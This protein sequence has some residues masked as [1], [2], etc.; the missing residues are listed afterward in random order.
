[1]QRVF[2]TSESVTE[3]HPD[4][5]ADRISDAVLDALL[6]EDKQAHVA[7]ETFLTTGLV[8]VGGEISTKVYVD[9]DRVV[10]RVAKEVGYDKAAYGFN[11][12]DC[13]VLSTIK[14]Q[15]ADIAAAVK[16]AKEARNGVAADLYDIIGAG[17]QGIMYGYACCGT[18]EL[19]PL[20]IVLAHSLTKRLARLRKDVVLPYLRPDGKSQVTIEY[21]RGRPIRASAILIAAQHDPDVAQTTLE[22]DMIE[23]VI[24]PVMENWIDE[25]TELLVNLSGRFVIGGPASDTGMTGRKIIVDTYGGYGSH[26][27]GAFSGKDPTK[28]DRSGAYMARYVAKNIVAAGLAREVEVQLAYAIGRAAPLS[29]NIDSYG[30]GL[31]TDGALRSAVIK[32]FDLRPGAIIER[33]D[34]LRPIY[35]QFSCYGHFGRIDLDP[36]WEKTDRLEELRSALPRTDRVV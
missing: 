4:K 3:G 23:Q 21:E 10:R 36:P 9:I 28:V 22:E 25:K 7:C 12:R 19:M 17:D 6:A 18:D 33:F 1:M 24:R 8:I 16:T 32:V 11:Y 13:A 26:G 35:E 14:E 2:L 31:V 15:S 30:T 27:G 34:L 5:V 29:L 20:P